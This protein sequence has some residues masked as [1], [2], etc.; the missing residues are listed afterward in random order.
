MIKLKIVHD[1]CGRE[2]SAWALR[3]RDIES[4]KASLQAYIDGNHAKKCR[5]RK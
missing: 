2:F 4:E 1:K 3:H 5:G